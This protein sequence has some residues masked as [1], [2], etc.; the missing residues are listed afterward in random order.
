[1]D[2]GFSGCINQAKQGEYCE[3]HRKQKAR[4]KPM[5]PLRDYGRTAFQQ[6]V[7]AACDLADLSA[8]NNEGWRRSRDYLRTCALRYVLSLPRSRKKS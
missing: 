1:M 3:S 4:G 7:A 5:T 2:C 6:L 8:T